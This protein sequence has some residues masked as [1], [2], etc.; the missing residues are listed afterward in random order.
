MRFEAGHREQ[1]D[2]HGF[3]V[4][5]CLLDAAALAPAI[6]ELEMMFPSVEG[7]HDGTD[8]RRARFLDDEFD[9]ID[10]FPFDSSELSL[11]AVADPLVHLARGLLDDHDLRL[12]TAE[13]WAKYTGAVDYDQLLHRDYLNHTLVAPTEDRR[14]AQVELFVY[15][16]DVP[17]ELGPPHPV[18][19]TL[20]HDLPARPNWHP[21]EDHADDGDPF[22]AATGRADLY[23]A[24][25]SGAGP[26]GTV[27]A[28]SPGTLHRGTALCA[29]RGVRYTLHLGFRPAS[30]EWGHRLS[31]A[32]RSHD[33]AWYAFATRAT[34]D[35]LALFGFPAAGSRLLDSDHD[36]RRR[37]AL[38]RPRPRTLAMSEEE[39]EQ[40]AFDQITWPVRTARLL[41]RPARA[42]DLAV[43]W[44]YRRLPE[45]TEWMSA[46]P[47]SLN[48]YRVKFTDPP[49]WPRRCSSSATAS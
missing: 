9:G 17:D 32:D 15:L 1:W 40:P 11:L 35:Q 39:R 12:Y 3:V 4:L 28:F 48:A 29:P 49:G 23:D 24:E 27:V 47:A 25:V 33:P 6:S 10:S 18:S 36:R 42:E 26:A 8:P 16:L 14:F 45:V 2:A 44:R 38:P 7:F 34:P 31:W 22:F 37:G 41:L 43:T 46:A 21:R 20:T 13:A 30:V 5:P 19:H